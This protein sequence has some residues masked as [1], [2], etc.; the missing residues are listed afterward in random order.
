MLTVRKY[1]AYFLTLN[2]ADGQIPTTANE[3]GGL[4]SQHI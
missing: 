4:N 3:G 1:L 2:Y